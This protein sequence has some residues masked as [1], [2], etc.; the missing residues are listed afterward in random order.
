MG[1]SFA[2][3]ALSLRWSF[4]TTQRTVR[5]LEAKPY[6]MVVRATN[7][8][9]LSYSKSSTTTSRSPILYKDELPTPGHFCSKVIDKCNPN[10]DLLE[11]WAATQVT[12]TGRRM[13]GR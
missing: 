5:E 6:I 10:E 9:E 7:Q 4:S 13:G 1:K 11:L 8:H 2:D 3:I 12:T